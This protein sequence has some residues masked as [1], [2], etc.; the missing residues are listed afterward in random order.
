MGGGTAGTT[1][2]VTWGTL[3]ANGGTALFN[4]SGVAY[5]LRM[6]GNQTDVSGTTFGALTGMTLQLTGNLVLGNRSATPGGVDAN[7]LDTTMANHVQGALF[8]NSNATP[9]AGAQ[10]M[11]FPAATAVGLYQVATTGGVAK[12]VRVGT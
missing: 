1:V 5:T 8:W 10:A 4:Q 9:N 12:F 2:E 6:G 3:K 7:I 11:G